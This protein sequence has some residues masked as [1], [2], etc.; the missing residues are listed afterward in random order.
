LIGGKMKINKRTVAREGLMIIAILLLLG[1]ALFISAKVKQN[2][3]K[4]LAKIQIESNV[5]AYNEKKGQQYKKEKSGDFD[6][7]IYIAQAKILEKQDQ[8]TRSTSVLNNI[9]ILLIAVCP[10][11][12]VIR[13]VVW[14]IKTLR[15]K[16]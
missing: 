10:V 1:T 15:I 11:Y 6:R 7:A 3:E 13:F 9:I 5:E 16:S 2:N 4:E 12:L 8:W 14:S